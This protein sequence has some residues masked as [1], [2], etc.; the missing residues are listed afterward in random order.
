MTKFGTS[1]EYVIKT[2]RNN[3]H[4]AHELIKELID[5][6]IDAKSTEIDIEIKGKAFTFLDNGKGITKKRFEQSMENIGSSLSHELGDIG[7]FNIGMKAC[8]IFLSD[9]FVLSTN[10]GED[11][12]KATINW[13]DPDCK[14]NY[15]NSKFNDKIGTEI[16]V[17]HL[18]VDLDKS[19]SII[20]KEISK[21][22]QRYINDGLKIK[23]NGEFILAAPEIPW[24]DKATIN[25]DG[26]YIDFGTW[27]VENKG[28]YN[29]YNIDGCWVWYLNRKVS[30]ESE[31]YD[32]LSSINGNYSVQLYI[33]DSSKYDVGYIKHY[34]E[35]AEDIIEHHSK[36]IMLFIKPSIEKNRQ[37]EINA[38]LDE[39]SAELS[40]V[41]YDIGQGRK[42]LR[43]HTREGTVTP[44]GTDIKKK[45]WKHGDDET[46][47]HNIK[48]K[49]TN[50]SVQNVEVRIKRLEGLT[51]VD[52]M[53]N[54]TVVYIDDTKE[55][56][57]ILM[58]DKNTL[59]YIVCE[60]IEVATRR[61]QAL[62]YDE[63]DVA[64]YNRIKSRL[65]K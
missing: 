5:N 60:K 10:T 19:V 3:N 47:N 63:L 31:K 20:R 6:S 59:K 17:V 32:C 13:N 38:T 42:K 61:G 43:E 14:I 30:R 45:N 41:P 36:Q 27:D 65:H 52:I 57:K 2:T 21:T 35:Q 50:G 24:I 12:Y 53:R 15:S 34:V 25:G 48:N 23:L 4:K 64:I 58:E 7:K 40:G 16:S 49:T 55:E 1:F 22:Y 11:N 56:M 44:K 54:K 33:T 39:I 9:E 37:V 28:L 46:D 18:R 62:F 29:I 8:L 26:Y 51:Q